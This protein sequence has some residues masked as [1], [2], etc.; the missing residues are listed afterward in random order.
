MSDGPEFACLSAVQESLEG[1]IVLVTPQAEV[2][3]L[4]NLVPLQHSFRQKAHRCKSE[5]AILAWE[6]DAPRSWKASREV[7]SRKGKDVRKHSPRNHPIYIH[8]CSL[9]TGTNCVS[10]L[11]SYS[12]SCSEGEIDHWD[13]LPWSLETNSRPVVSNA[14]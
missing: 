13:L 6:K 8:H 4:P 7:P 14:H 10:M 5:F 9:T 3:S 12:P 11:L 2:E 1:M